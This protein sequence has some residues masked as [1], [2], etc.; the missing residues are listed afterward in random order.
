MQLGV[1]K[2]EDLIGSSGLEGG[3]VEMETL[4]RG[5]LEWSREGRED[6]GLNL[7]DGSRGRGNWL[8]S[9]SSGM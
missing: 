8:E 3:R 6:G 4:V 1:D 5:L 9:R 7:V 2:T